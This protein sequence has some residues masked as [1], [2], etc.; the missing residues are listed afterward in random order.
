YSSIIDVR[1]F[2]WKIEKPRVCGAGLNFN[3]H[4]RH[5]WLGGAHERVERASRTGI[6]AL[7]S[8]ETAG[9]QTDILLIIQQSAESWLGTDR[10]ATTIYCCC[11]LTKAEGWQHVFEEFASHRP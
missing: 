3:V 9:D 7:H 10:P 8:R 1:I 11:D 2:T 5:V 6:E 4:G